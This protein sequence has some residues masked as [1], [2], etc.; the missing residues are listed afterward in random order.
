MFALYVDILILLN[1]NIVKKSY[2]AVTL[3]LPRM[4]EGVGRYSH[5]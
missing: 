3:R 4:R 2:T 1:K 5:G